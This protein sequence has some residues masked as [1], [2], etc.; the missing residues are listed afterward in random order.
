MHTIRHIVNT[1]AES[2]RVT[3]YPSRHFRQSCR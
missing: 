2:Y 1:R 3:L